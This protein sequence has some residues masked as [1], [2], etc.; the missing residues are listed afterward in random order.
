MFIIFC[1]FL[2]IEQIFLSAQV[3]PSVIITKKTWY[4]R[5]ASQVVERLESQDLKTFENIRKII[6]ELLQNNG[7]V[8]SPPL[9]MKIL[10][11]LTKIS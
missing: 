11:L 8:L 10:S 7:L 2:M 1:D 4:I 6:I 9:E 3:K 5:V